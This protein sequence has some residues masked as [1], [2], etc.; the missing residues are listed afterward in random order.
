[1]SGLRA[2]MLFATFILAGSLV[3]TVR[4][5][6]VNDVRQVVNVGLPAIDEGVISDEPHTP[7]STAAEKRARLAAALDRD[8]TGGSGLRF[9]PGRVIVK[10]KD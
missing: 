5:Q 6:T 10:F 2:G 7:G 8:R 3:L 4:G 1:M 9:T